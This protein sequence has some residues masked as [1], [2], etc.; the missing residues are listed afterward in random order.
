MHATRAGRHLSGA[1][2]LVSAENLEAT[3]MALM[4]RALQHTRGA[5]EQLRLSIDLVPGGEVKEIGL[6]DLRTC[7]VDTMEEGRRAALEALVHSSVAREVASGAMTCL[8]NGADGMGGSM[9]GAMLIDA[10][11]GRRLD[12]DPQR[13]VRASRHDIRE[14]ALARLRAQLQPLGLDNEHVREALVLA[15]KVRSAPGVI[16]ELCWSDDPAYTAGYVCSAA[17]GYLRFPHLKQAGDERGGRVFFVR[18]AGSGPETLCRYLE[19]APVLVTRVAAC[20]PPQPW[21]EHA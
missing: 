4:R 11:S 10:D 19:C 14:D 7:A 17:V 12:A 16:A 18:L 15:A 6:P 3:G 13:G 8:A 5:A 20:H 21:R 1:E 2:R 9:R